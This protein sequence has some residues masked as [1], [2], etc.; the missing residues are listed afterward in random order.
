MVFN[1]GNRNH[2]RS[3]DLPHC[4]RYEVLLL[5]SLPLFWAKSFSDSMAGESN[6]CSIGEETVEL[7]VGL[8]W[9]FEISRY[10]DEELQQVTLPLPEQML[11]V[12]T[13]VK[14]G[15]LDMP[16]ASSFVKGNSLVCKD[17]NAPTSGWMHV[18]QC[19]STMSSRVKLQCVPRPKQVFFAFDLRSGRGT[20]LIQIQKSTVRF[21]ALAMQMLAP[22]SSLF[23]CLGS[24]LIWESA[25]SPSKRSLSVKPTWK[26]ADKVKTCLFQKVLCEC[27]CSISIRKYTKITKKKR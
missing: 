18:Y 16:L 11:E 26:S 2:L 6:L 20:A 3:K 24:C 5:D 7:G 21:V 13:F 1:K 10:F 14:A 4:T 8:H 17:H 19:L 22:S 27:K 23:Q 9:Q 12:T 15:R 25:E